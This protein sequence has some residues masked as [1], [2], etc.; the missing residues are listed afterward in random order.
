MI[1]FLVF[2]AMIAY[3]IERFVLICMLR[4][5]NYSQ[6]TTFMEL[7]IFGIFTLVGIAFAMKYKNRRK[8][9]SGKIHE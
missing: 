2:I 9:L 4:P 1:G 5:I 7:I 8:Y 3:N 6:A